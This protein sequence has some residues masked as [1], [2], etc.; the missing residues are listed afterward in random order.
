MSNA[1]TTGRWTDKFLHIHVRRPLLMYE[2]SWSIV[3]KSSFAQCH[4]NFSYNSLPPC[5]SSQNTKANTKENLALVSWRSKT[6]INSSLHPNSSITVTAQ[7]LP[8]PPRKLYHGCVCGSLHTSGLDPLD[9]KPR[10]WLPVRALGPD[11]HSHQRTPEP[12]PA[13]N[14][15]FGSFRGARRCSTV[16]NFSQWR[17]KVYQTSR[18]I[19]INKVWWRTYTQHAKHLFPNIPGRLS[20]FPSRKK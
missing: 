2:H 20:R 10:V 9:A 14:T 19:I 15:R 8:S 7:P 1:R 18:N 6:K 3:H 13:G 4:T 5:L 17:T 11:Q 16:A 12:G